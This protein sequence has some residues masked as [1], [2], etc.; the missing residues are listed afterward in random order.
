MSRNVIESPSS[1]TASVEVESYTKA[2]ERNIREITRRETAAY[3][4]V[5]LMRTEEGRKL[6]FLALEP[7]EESAFKAP[8]PIQLPP[9]SEQVPNRVT[10]GLD[11]PMMYYAAA[12][13]ATEEIFSSRPLQEAA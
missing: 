13:I 6:F 11:H 3:D 7:K 5:V 12:G 8:E 2:K 1:M 4:V 10:H 9:P